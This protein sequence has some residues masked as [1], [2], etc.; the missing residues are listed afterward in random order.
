[1]PATAPTV[2][3][4]ARL[5][6]DL[7]GLA[8]EQ[9][10]L[11]LAL[12]RGAGWLYRMNLDSGR[13]LYGWVPALKTRLEGDSYLHQAGAAF[14]LARAARLTGED[15]HIARAKQAIL[16]LIDETTVDDR[17]HP[18]VCYTALPSLVIN[19]LGAAG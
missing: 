4:L 14:A 2:V 10:E 12:Q 8:P 11:V 1:P 15:Q 16:T 3:S 17:D 7:K 18:R 13:F 9:Q 6:L 5:N 19:R